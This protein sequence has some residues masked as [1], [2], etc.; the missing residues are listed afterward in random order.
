MS[1]GAPQWLRGTLDDAL[2][3]LGAT[4][5]AEDREA[6]VSRLLSCWEGLEGPVPGFRFLSVM[7]EKLDLLDGLASDSDLLHL[8]MAYRGSG[9][10]ADWDDLPVLERLDHQPDGLN[11]EDAERLLKLGLPKETVH[12]IDEL[13]EQLQ[14]H[15]PLSEDLDGQ[16]LVDA[17][18][19]VL[20]TSPQ[21][22][23]RL[24]AAIMEKP[25]TDPGELV[26]R[27]R[28]F[29][30]GLLDRPRIYY[31]PVA[32]E[33]EEIARQN[34]ESELANL[35]ARNRDKS[36]ISRADKGKT[37]RGDATAEPEEPPAQNRPKASG[38][39]SKPSVVVM[40]SASPRRPTP[41]NANPQALTETRRAPLIKGFA[42]ALA[43]GQPGNRGQ[44]AF[45]A[46]SST[47][48]SAADLIERHRR[49]QSSK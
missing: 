3:H 41:T 27:R 49:N 4:A 48:E 47:L 22:Y 43:T 12:R 9:E 5:S 34:L 30:Q 31:T 10:S 26:E 36:G 16:I 17:D 11:E 23:K 29:V 21:A 28:K 46:T 15:L 38:E 19:S 37:Q 33:W 20:A 7:F 13:L 14:H 32:A 42:D 45:S 25:Q 44:D 40:R 35:E 2:V 8:A 1:S 6:E 39:S 18:M 24:V